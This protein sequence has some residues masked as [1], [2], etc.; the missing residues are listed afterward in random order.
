V[1]LPVKS[2]WLDG[3]VVAMRADG[4]TDFSTLQSAFRKKATSQ[5]VY[6]VFDVLYLDGYDLRPCP[7][8]ERKR[9]L[10]AILEKPPSRVQH[11]EHVEGRGVEFFEQCRAMGLEGIVCKRADRCHTPGRNRDWIKVK[12]NRR[13][14][15]VVIGWLDP[16]TRRRGLGA[17]LLGSF[18][19]DGTLQYEGRVGTGFSTRVEGELLTT[20]DGLVETESPVR[21]RLNAVRRKTHWVRPELVAAV[22]FLERTNDGELRHPSFQGLLNLAASSIVRDR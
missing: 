20:L 11:V 7:L 22:E 17:L 5:L 18:A 2:A 14:N 9:L 19:P 8:I 12:C 1:K 13:E 3:E 4:I 10:A 21:N 15:F 6:S 16:E